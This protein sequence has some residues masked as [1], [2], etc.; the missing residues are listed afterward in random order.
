VTE[1]L[2]IDAIAPPGDPNE[3]CHGSIRVVYAYRNFAG[4]MTQRLKLT[5]ADLAELK[6]FLLNTKL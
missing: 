6:N 1:I 2:R 4:T 3:G 5:D